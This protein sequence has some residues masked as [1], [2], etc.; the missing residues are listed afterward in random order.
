[1]EN[2]GPPV[3]L[4][5]IAVG[6]LNV[7]LIGMI[8]RLP[9]TDEKT[10]MEKMVISPGGGG[11][12][13]AVACSKLGLK[14][15]FVGCVGKD[16]FGDLILEKFRAEKIDISHIRR[17]AAPTGIA[18]VLSTSKGEHILVSHRG[19]NLSLK[20]ADISNEYLKTAKLIHVSSKPPKIS[21]AIA[22]KAKKLGMH[23]SID[24]GAELFKLKIKELSDVISGYTTCFLNAKGF[25]R[26]FRNRPSRKTILQKFPSGI[27]NLVVTLGPKGAVASDG[28]EIIFCN[29]PRVKVKDT[30]GAGDAFAAAFDAIWLRDHDLERSLVYAVAEATIKVQYIGAQE[31]LPEMDELE[32]FVEKNKIR[33]HR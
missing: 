24:I 29:P 31:G 11:A 32:K 6:N 13:F 26:I 19:A 33:C 9:R 15:G 1:M 7:D 20:L 14:V 5:V 3:K 27:K 8:D 4:D 28:K 16:E 10:L 23:A 25:K 30:T 21:R 22:I 2:M 12:N 17:V 18:I